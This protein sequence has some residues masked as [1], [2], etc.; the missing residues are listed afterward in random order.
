[1]SDF[2]SSSCSLFSQLG[3]DQFCHFGRNVP[4]NI[5]YQSL[6]LYCDMLR[7]HRSLNAFLTVYLNIYFTP[8]SDSSLLYVRTLVVKWSNESH[9]S[10]RSPHPMELMILMRG[11]Q[12]ALMKSK[13]IKPER[14]KL[15]GTEGTRLHGF[16]TS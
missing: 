2:S 10:Q 3:L 15:G 16:Q 5:F 1:M 4:S 9:K 7:F 6:N 13:L 14:L 12:S 8:F 11:Y